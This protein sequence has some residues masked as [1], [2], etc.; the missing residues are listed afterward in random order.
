MKMTKICT[1]CQKEKNISEFNKDCHAPDG[2]RYSC[3][4]CNIVLDKQK[5]NKK[6]EEKIKNN[7]R[8]PDVPNEIWKDIDNY[9]GLYQ[10]SNKGRVKILSRLKKIRKSKGDTEPCYLSEGLK[11]FRILNGYEMVP[12]AKDSKTNWFL[13]HRLI[14]LAFL[15]NPENLP[16]VH[17]IDHNRLNNHIENLVWVTH[18]TNSEE[19]SKAGRL[20]KIPNEKKTKSVLPQPEVPEFYSD[21]SLKLDDEIWLDIK[22]YEN[23]YKISNH[24]RVIS[25]KR[26]YVPNNK[27]RKPTIWKN[28]KNDSYL[29]IGLTDGEESKIFTLHRLVALHFL[30]NPNNLPEVNHKNGNKLDANVKNLEWITCQDNIIHALENNLNTSRGE[31]SPFTKLTESK[32]LEIRKLYKEGLTTY[33]LEKMFGVKYYTIK[34][35]VDRKSWKHI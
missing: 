14:A 3:R 4:Y 21:N 9:E 34:A 32:V 12:L 8:I 2:I 19:A 5:R 35:I 24:G 13:V 18:K 11:K 6:R 28:K 1:K 17:H 33:R 29:Y 10:I 31:N 26:R 20:I 30:E 15:E 16:V 27:L 7:N 25:L 22:G 23:K